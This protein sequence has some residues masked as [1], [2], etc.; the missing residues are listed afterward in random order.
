MRSSVRR[1]S[2]ELSVLSVEKSRLCFLLDPLGMSSSFFLQSKSSQL[3]ASVPSV[4]RLSPPLSLMLERI[5]AI[6]GSIPPF[7][8]FLPLISG[9]VVDGIP[10]SGREFTRL[11]AAGM[12]FSVVALPCWIEWVVQASVASTS[13]VVKGRSFCSVI[14]LDVVEVYERLLCED[15]GISSS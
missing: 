5:R 3:S 11:C 1:S 13:P 8:S 14:S 10:L 9:E 6:G 15:K 2:R 7:S 4:V 12:V